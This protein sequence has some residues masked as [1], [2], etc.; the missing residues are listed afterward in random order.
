MDEALVRDLNKA[1]AA[2]ENRVDEDNDDDRGDDDAR[3]SML[4]KL[5]NATLRDLCLQHNVPVRSNAVKSVLVQS[6]L[7]LDP[8]IKEDL[9]QALWEERLLGKRSSTS[10]CTPPSLASAQPSRSAPAAFTPPSVL[11]CEA[12]GVG[13][14]PHTMNPKP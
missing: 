4:Q 3:E 9:V 10:A 12:L 2:L 14:K 13:G 8:P 7:A 1:L 11:T 6:L 5:T